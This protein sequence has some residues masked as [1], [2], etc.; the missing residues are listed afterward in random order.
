MLNGV[1]SSCLELLPK[2]AETCTSQGVC[3]LSDHLQGLVALSI[4]AK[5]ANWFTMQKVC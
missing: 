4:S 2:H 3:E 1:Q 5:H